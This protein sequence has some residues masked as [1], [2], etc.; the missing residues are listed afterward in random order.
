MA[1]LVAASSGES[2]SG[3]KHIVFGMPHPLLNYNLGRSHHAYPGKILPRRRGPFRA[4]SQ[5]PVAGLHDGGGPRRHRHPGLEQIESRA[6]HRRL[7]TGQRARRG[8]CSGAAIRLEAAL[9]RGRRSHQPRHRRPL[10]R[11][12]RFLHARRGRGHR[13]AGRGGP[14][15][16]VHRAASGTAGD[17]EHS[18][19]RPAFHHRLAKP[20]RRSPASTW[21]RCSRRAPSTGT[22]TSKRGGRA[23]ITEVSMDETDA[24]QTPPE[25]LVILAAIADERIP[26]QTIAPKFTGPLQ[27]GRGLRGRCGAVREGV[28][29]R[30]GRDRL[31]HPAVRP[32]RQ[33][34]AER[35][36]GQ[37]QV[38]DLRPHPAGAARS[39]APGCT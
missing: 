37:R 35:A 7:R 16:R 6:R 33:P 32:A 11:R 39:S 22:S 20:S 8:R 30:P 27:Q 1:A 26:I 24:P 12:Q 18:R 21:R 15:R 36:F 2:F 10:H 31:R 4:P 25:L 17:R 9:P 3:A 13:P 19:H 29:R 38:L 34:E 5:G 23:F 14:R 28:Q